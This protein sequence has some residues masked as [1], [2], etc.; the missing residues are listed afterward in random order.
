MD[1]MMTILAIPFEAIERALG[2]RHFDDHADGSLLQPLRG[3][4]NMFWQQKDLALFDRNLERRLA[5]S[6]NKAKKNVALQLVEKFFRRIIMIVAPVVR[7]TDYGNHHFAV[8]PHLRIADRRLEFLFV[9]FDPAQKIERLQ[10]L[11]GR[12]SGSYFSGL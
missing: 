7:T 2:S 11:D 9:L 6:F 5:R 12:H 8:F 4:T 10:V 1:Q 3:M